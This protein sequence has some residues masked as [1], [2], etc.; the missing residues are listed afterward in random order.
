MYQ[1][2]IT[3]KRISGSFVLIFACCI[4]FSCQKAFT[5]EQNFTS[6]GTLATN[7]AG[8]C[9]PVNINGIFKAG[10]LLGSTNYIDVT[11][12]VTATGSYSISTD[13]LNGFYFS[14][15]ADFTS[16]GTQIVRLA[17]HGTPVTAGAYAFTAHYNN[18]SSCAVQ[19]TVSP[20]GTGPVAVFT[21]T[22]APGACTTPIIQGTYTAGT[23]LDPFNRIIVAVNVT[24]LGEYNLTTAVVNG[25]SFSATGTF[26]IP[27]NQNV[28]LAGSGTPTSNG[29]NTMS[30]TGTVASCSFPL[31]VG[32]VTSGGTILKAAYVL[33]QS[34]PA[35][36]DTVGWFNVTYDAQNRP[37][38][39]TQ[40]S[41]NAVGD[42]VYYESVRYE[43]AGTDS[44]ASRA[45][46]YNKDFNSLPA[47]INY[48][49]AYFGFSNAKMV[50]DS[51]RYAG[52]YATEHFSYGAG[53]ITHFG[54]SA[55]NAGA[56]ITISEP[57]VIR[58]TLTNGNN[59]YQLDTMVLHSPGAA[60]SNYFYNRLEHITSYVN[61]PNPFYRVE[62]PRRREFFFK[63]E[64]GI[65][66]ESGAPANLIQEQ[67]LNLKSWSGTNPPSINTDKV[68]YTST[69]NTN[70]YPAAAIQVINNIGTI[71]TSKL[72]F[73][74]Q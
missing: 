60:P 36:H 16:T 66:M 63:D 10:V 6:A 29:T 15:S 31:T 46:T 65:Y 55:T 68:T 35:L 20:A 27:G 11:V 12:H 58:I 8:N 59:V 33:D 2:K 67:T 43:Y 37:L 23:M 53:G 44:F 54:V 38:I 51:V 70:G 13:T 1:E 24:A 74:Y 30:I 39:V 14:D 73:V 61:N 17:A 41:R 45:F 69:L 50:L 62:R 9:D 25:I 72:V 57:S 4:F 26:T 64:F 18:S 21:L 49:T 22:G 28:V 48:D 71:T 32:S 7:A 34:L 42:S 56:P 40:L 5:P 3:M 52:N 19:V 47:S